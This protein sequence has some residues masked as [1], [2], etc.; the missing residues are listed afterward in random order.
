MLLFRILL[1]EVCNSKC[2]GLII[3]FENLSLVTESRWMKMISYLFC[4][5]ENYLICISSNHVFIQQQQ[6]TDWSTDLLNAF[7]ASWK[8]QAQQPSSTSQLQLCKRTRI[9]PCGLRWLQICLS[10]YRTSTWLSQELPCSF[11]EVLVF[12]AEGNMISVNSWY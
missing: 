1:P 8:R 7:S 2:L 4:C 5:W 11:H 10:P 12:H 6:L 3:L 9:F